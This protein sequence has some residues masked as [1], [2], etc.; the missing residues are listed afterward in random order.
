MKYIIALLLAASPVLASAAP[1]N[2]KAAVQ[3]AIAQ[4]YNRPLAAHNCQLTEPPKD[5]E[6]AS[7]NIMYC[8][9]SVADHSVTRNGK[10]TRYV[11][12]T[13]FA[14]DMKL[15]I[16]Q[17][18]HASSGLAELFVLEKT[19]GKWTI[20]QHGK[21]EIGAWGDVPANKAWQFVQ[22]GEQ[23]WGYAVESGYTG[24]G[25]TTTGRN[26]LFTDNSNRIRRSFIVNGKDNG[27]YYSNC[28]V[29]KG[30]EKRDCED[31]Y[32]SIDAKIAFDKSRPSVSGVWALN[33]TVKG[34]DGKKRYK[35]QKYVVP[36]DGKT[37][38]A[39]KSY[40]LNVQH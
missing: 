31:R 38:V 22:M 23:N 27:A 34:V 15:K 36:Y 12:Y 13:G 14:Y 4:Y 40:P 7:D 25:E 17:G 19:D 33:A 28:D 21:D 29:Y 20:K 3:A 9:K 37:H 35:N 11:L 6:T 26:F 30:R 2:D 18:A 16:K 10:A 1:N 24:Q 39:P 32:T 5:S 8:M